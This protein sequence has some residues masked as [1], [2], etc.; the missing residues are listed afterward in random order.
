MFVDKIEQTTEDFRDM[1]SLLVNRSLTRTDTH[2]VEELIG[3]WLSSHNVL[4]MIRV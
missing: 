2:A 4:S 1:P 3:F